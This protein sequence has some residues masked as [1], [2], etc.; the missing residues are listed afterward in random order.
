MIIRLGLLADMCKMIV[1]GNYNKKRKFNFQVYVLD[2]LL[3][4]DLQLKYFR[5]KC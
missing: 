2:V 3:K 4:N 5:R 1:F